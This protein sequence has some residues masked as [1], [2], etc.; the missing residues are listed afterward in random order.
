MRSVS[1]GSWR[2]V[3]VRSRTCESSVFPP[4]DRRT[5][6]PSLIALTLYSDLPSSTPPE[7]TGL[8]SDPSRVVLCNQTGGGVHLEP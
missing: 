4:H 5:I 8:T 7:R 2:V 3:P 6:D 1:G